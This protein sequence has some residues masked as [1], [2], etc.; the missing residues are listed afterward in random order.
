MNFWGAEVTGIGDETVEPLVPFMRAL[1]ESGRATAR[2]LYGVANGGWVA[3]GFA[4]LSRDS[5]AP[6]QLRH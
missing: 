6:L 2:E 4:R 5:G 3:H 1:A